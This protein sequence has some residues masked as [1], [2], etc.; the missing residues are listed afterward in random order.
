MQSYDATGASQKR[1]KSSAGGGSSGN[2]S[3]FSNERSKLNNVIIDC[4]EGAQNIYS[5]CDNRG[6]T[7]VNGA[8]SGSATGSCGGAIISGTGNML[9]DFQ[10]AYFNQ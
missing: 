3:S 6:P 5:S 8:T 2:H 10:A 7:G 1:Y 4:L 9:S